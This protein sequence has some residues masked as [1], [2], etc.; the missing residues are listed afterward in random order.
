MTETIAPVAEAAPTN[1]QSNTTAKPYDDELLDAYAEQAAA[2]AADEGSPEK[3]PA[4]PVL[5]TETT[6]VVPKQVEEPKVEEKAPENKAT[7]DDKVSDGIEDIPL[8]RIINGKEVQFKVN[9]AITAYIKQEEFNRNM[10]R[11]ST[12]LGQKEKRF[13]QEKGIAQSNIDKVME[14]V[15]K[16]DFVSTIRALAKIHKSGSDSSVVETEKKYFSQ[17]DKIYEVYGKL[18]P[19]QRESY[20]TKRELED[21]KGSARQLEEEKTVE[22]AKSQLQEKVS[23]LQKQYGLED[24]EF[25]TN[26]KTI[27]EG[28]VGEGKVFKS[29]Q[30]IRPEDVVRFSLAV[31][32]EQKVIDAAGKYG[33]EDDAILDQISKITAA[34]QT[35]SVEDIARVIEASGIAKNADPKAVENLN[36]KAGKSKI[37]FSQ[38]SSTKKENGKYE[39]IDS[40]DVDFLYRKQ[41]KVFARPVR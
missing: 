19:D 10:D 6:P 7:K 25:W 24:K 33:I 28:Q 29:A 13:E 23:S 30:E 8:K 31:R 26:Y 9:D 11:R 36:R 21:A 22:T 14:A 12:S 16:G 2:E 4:I 5:K 35:L 20:W 38:G 3:A 1:V 40:E 37:Q 27:A 41:P 15:S 18:T 17:L 32:H 34:D 39:G